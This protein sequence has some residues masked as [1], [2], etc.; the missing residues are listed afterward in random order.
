MKVSAQDIN[1]NAKR[2][3]VLIKM[4]LATAYFCNMQKLNIGMEEAWRKIKHYC[5]YQERNHRET[6]EK[7]YSFGLYK[8]EVEQLLSQLVE[9]NYLNEERFVIA[10]A[11][12]H[13]RMK[14]WGKSKIKYELRQKGIGEYLIKKALNSIDDKEYSA[15]F[16]KLAMAKLALLKGEKNIFIKKKKVQQY[17]FQK[18]FEHD[19]IA[20]FVN[21][22]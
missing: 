13:F 7:L 10:Y 3:R 17:L 1:F 19:M 14:Q 9:E 2:G 6:K 21:N 22:I 8:A 12:G 11:G 5:A 18:G 20:G 16:Q 15:T 4:M